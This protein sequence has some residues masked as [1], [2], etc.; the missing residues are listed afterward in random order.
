MRTT[1]IYLLTGA[2][3]LLTT[4]LSGCHSV[5]TPGISLYVMPD[6]FPY[7]IIF[8]GDGTYSLYRPQLRT[9]E[10]GSWTAKGDT[11][12]CHY[13]AET[14]LCT[15]KEGI[16]YHAIYEGRKSTTVFLLN[17]DKLIEITPDTI[18]EELRKY[19]VEQGISKDI[20][21]KIKTS[22]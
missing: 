12:I 18:T 9:S 1:M 14:S 11:I 4:T 5:P 3:T 8:R 17:K 15:N 22:R 10:I 7:S 2:L 20:Y 6:G 13:V 16:D 19:G 21:S